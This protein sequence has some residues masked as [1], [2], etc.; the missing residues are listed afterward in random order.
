[1]KPRNP[2]AFDILDRSKVFPPILDSRTRN[3]GK[4]NI[5]DMAEKDIAI[6]DIKPYSATILS[7]AT[8]KDENAAIV[9]RL[10]K[11]VFLPIFATAMFSAFSFPRSSSS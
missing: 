6:K 1:M 3:D 5:T 2:R 9:V 8:A 4:N 7:P 10:V 11:I